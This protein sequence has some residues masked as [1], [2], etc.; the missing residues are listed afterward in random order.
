MTPAPTAWLLL[1]TG[2]AVILDA[3]AVVLLVWLVGQVLFGGSQLFE[4]E[5]RWVGAIGGL[6]CVLNPGSRRSLPFPMLAYV[7]IAAL[8]AA[9]HQW[10]IVGALTVF[11]WGG[12]FLPALNLITMAIFVF[13]G[14]H[15]LRTPWRQSAFMVFLAVAIHVLAA[16]MLFDRTMTGFVYNEGGSSSL[17][18]VS[19]WGGLHQTGLLLVIGLPLSLTPSIIERS[20]SRTVTG[21]VLG[22]W[23]LGIALL[24]GSRAGISVM[25]A[26]LMFM[27]GYRLW[28]ATRFKFTR[29]ILAAVILTVPAGLWYAA[30]NVT[31][32][33]RAMSLSAASGRMPIWRAAANIVRDHP[34][35]GVGPGNYTVAMLD[36][37][38]AEKLLYQVEGRYSGAE[39]AHNLLIHVAAETGVFGALFLLALFLWLVRGCWRA[40]R[41]GEVPL[42]SAGLLCALL[43]FLMRSMSD[44]FLDGLITTDRTRV[45]VWALFAA[46]LAVCRLPL[47]VEP[48]RS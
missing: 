23:L 10:P 48:R 20:V 37:G 33:M 18:S 34:W 5:A 46:A 11:N 2:L 45:L 40:F 31:T 3:V 35:L 30:S 22:G 17:P 21:L 42:V 38:Y 12:L 27:V 16:Q 36:G 8:S 47:T 41:A 29:A 44:D 4:T 28:T 25:A 7:S 14:A 32:S 26:T 43:A 39:Q 1:R 19:Q 9:I 13:G 6:A 15:L 24:N